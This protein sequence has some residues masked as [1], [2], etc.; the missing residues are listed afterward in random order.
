MKVASIIVSLFAVAAF[1]NPTAST[2][3]TKVE[4]KK[5]AVVATET[6][7]VSAD[8]KKVMKKK[9]VKKAEGVKAAAPAAKVETKVEEKKENK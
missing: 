6:K 9:V 8:G 3:T 1:A 4:A 2:T 7:A 5:P